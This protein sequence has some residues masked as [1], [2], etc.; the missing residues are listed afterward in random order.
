ML[1][2]SYTYFWLWLTT[3]RAAREQ[4]QAI[5]MKRFEKSITSLSL[6]ENKQRENSG[7]DKLSVISTSGTESLIPSNLCLWSHCNAPPEGLE[8]MVR[9]WETN[10][11][12]K[13]MI[14]DTA[15]WI[16]GAPQAKDRKSCAKRWAL[17]AS[18]PT[19]THKRTNVQIQSHVNS[20]CRP[21]Q[22]PSF[23][24]LNGAQ[25]LHKQPWP[26]TSP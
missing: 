26:L 12:S 18:Y 10:C 4:S 11:K 1:L 13:M 17:S 21:C 3:D 5:G 16:S 24:W 8:S 14:C 22:Q 15:R 23:V 9:I 20:H 7:V 6:G 2:S 19:H 25:R